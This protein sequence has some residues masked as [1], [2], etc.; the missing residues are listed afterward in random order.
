[1]YA[2]YPQ[3]QSKK[4]KRKRNK[5]TRGSANSQS[6]RN[7]LPKEQPEKKQSRQETW[8]LNT[9]PATAARP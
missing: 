9:V 1:M 2:N 8:V 7:S 5:S 4:K 3:I 6:A